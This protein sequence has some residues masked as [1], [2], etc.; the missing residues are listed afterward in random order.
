MEKSK[1]RA[2]RHGGSGTAPDLPS[3]S[4]RGRYKSMYRQTR[5]G[6]GQADPGTARAQAP[7]AAADKM[8][9]T[10]GHNADTTGH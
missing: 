3:L 7:P 1:P 6:P 9:T 8:R 5:G 10:P 2:K 4:V